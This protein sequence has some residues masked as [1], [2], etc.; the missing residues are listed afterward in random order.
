VADL[1]A[2]RLARNEATF[3]IVNERMAGW[4]ERH[5][6]EQPEPY[7]CECSDE[8]CRETI[9]LRRDEYEAVRTDSLRFVV[10]VGHGDMT[11]ERVVVNT[12]RYDVVLKNE[13]A[14]P[15]AERTDPRR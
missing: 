15:V 3:R 4:E 5:P 8:T 9:L 14:R 13:A 1:R 11:V 6:D 7:Y 12:D 2:E 10:A